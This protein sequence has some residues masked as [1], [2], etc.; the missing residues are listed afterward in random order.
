MG[1]C[2]WQ[3]C[4]SASRD[5]EHDD[6]AHVILCTCV[7]VGT[8]AAHPGGCEPLGRMSIRACELGCWK[9]AS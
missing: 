6:F 8:W 3:L 9:S 5:C 4:W 7:H 2:G 1:R